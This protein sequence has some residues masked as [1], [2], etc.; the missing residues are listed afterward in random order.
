MFTSAAHQNPFG[1]LTIAARESGDASADIDRIPLRI[2]DLKNCDPGRLHVDGEAGIVQPYGDFH[3]QSVVA[4]EQASGAHRIIK[5]C[6]FWLAPGCDLHVE[7]TIVSHEVRDS[8]AFR[9]CRL[10]AEERAGIGPVRNVAARPHEKIAVD[11]KYANAIGGRHGEMNRPNDGAGRSPRSWPSIGIAF[12]IDGEVL[13]SMAG[14][15]RFATYAAQ[16]YPGIAYAVRSAVPILT[17]QQFEYLEA[18]GQLMI[19]LDG[20]S[21]FK[22][23]E[24]A[25]SQIAELSR[26]WSNT[27][28]IVT[29]RTAHC[30]LIRQTLPGF[31]E[32]RV[33][34]LDA[35]AQ[36]RFLSTQSKEIQSAMQRAF[37]RWEGLRDLCGNQFLFLIA[38][39]MLPQS[40]GAHLDRTGLYHI[41][42]RRF[43][44]W[45]GVQDPDS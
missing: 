12:K 5:T 8:G 44:E 17:D 7:K 43:M 34:D 23:V 38:T 2:L 21:E 37:S 45:M 11:A 4:R 16:C 10:K 22:R 14:A 1:I 13:D 24:D 9:R 29:C 36:D 39:E 42:L 40:S 27:R 28:F 20:L 19:V 41:F 15:D 35:G 3:I 30:D 33:A 18:Q 32:W 31:D 6:A 26:V 25:A